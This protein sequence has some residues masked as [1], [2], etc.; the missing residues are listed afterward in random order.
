LAK[1]L[2]IGGASNYKWEDVRNW[3]KSIKATGF[4]GDIALVATNL[5]KA[6]IERL[7]KEDIKVYLY[8]AMNPEGGIDAPK[9]GIEP[10]VERFFYIWYYLKTVD[11]DYRFVVATDTRDVI[12]QR[13]PIEFLEASKLYSL[14]CASEGLRYEDEPWGAANFSNTFGPFFF[15]LYKEK[16]IYNVGVLGGYATAMQDLMNMIFQMCANRPIRVCDQ[17]AF[18]YLVH[19][20]PYSN[21]TRLCSHLDEYAIHLGT[22]EEAIKAGKGD[23]GIQYKHDPEVL[24]KYKADYLDRQPKFLSDGRVVNH[25]DQEFCIVHQYDRIPGLKEKIDGKYAD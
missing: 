11:E 3:V 1:D 22:T 13:N 16:M 12:F 20:E 17:A 21:E 15:D 24:T 23:I 19:L 25:H 7:D 5:D 9:N 6:T 14:A 4:E 2:I 18:N 10:H 8:G